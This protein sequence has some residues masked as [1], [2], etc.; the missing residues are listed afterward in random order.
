MERS[1]VVSTI[2]L[3]GL[4]DSLAGQQI[5]LLKMYCKGAELSFLAGQAERL[6]QSV[7][8]VVIEYHEWA[9]QRKETLIDELT[10]AGF[11]VRYQPDAA[12]SQGMLWA[13]AP[14]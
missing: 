9:G 2:N 11:A 5:D 4:L 14:Y 10:Q 8:Y 12:P 3:P 13:G 1:I 7:R 6:R